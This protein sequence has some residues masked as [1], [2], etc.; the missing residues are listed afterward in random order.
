MF[1]QEP[2]GGSNVR[3]MQLHRHHEEK[4]AAFILMSISF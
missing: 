3:H 2:A 4:D 1:H